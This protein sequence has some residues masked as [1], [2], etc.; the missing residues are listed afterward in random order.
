MTASDRDST[1]PDTSDTP[2][3][4]TLSGGVRVIAARPQDVPAMV[5]LLADDPIATARESDPD[6]AEYAAAFAEITADPRQL[7]VALLPPSLAA[8]A[9]EAEA[10]EVVGTLQLSFVPGLSRRG[11]TR[12]II[13][14]VR[15][16]PAAR[17]TGVGSELIRWA[18]EHGRERGAVLAQLTT[19]QRREDAHRFYR[20][21]G[22]EGTHLGMKLSL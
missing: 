4:A 16:A 10:D 17:G 6:G 15:I 7:L 19:D 8:A 20:R 11:A 3:L 21:L 13:E 1:T 12:M 5:R 2:V 22:F 9:G 18:L 14:A